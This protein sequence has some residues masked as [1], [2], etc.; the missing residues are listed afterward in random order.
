MVAPRAASLHSAEVLNVLTEPG[1]DLVEK[2][3]QSLNL[4]VHSRSFML[5]CDKTAGQIIQLSFLECNEGFGLTGSLLRL[6]D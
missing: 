2:E 4:F 1:A 6:Y 5:Q 3:R